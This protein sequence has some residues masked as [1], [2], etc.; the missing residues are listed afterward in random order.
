MSSGPPFLC[1]LALKINLH[2]QPSRNAGWLSGYQQTEGLQKKCWWALKGKTKKKKRKQ[3]WLVPKAIP[4]PPRQG[5]QQDCWLAL[6]GAGWQVFKG[7]CCLATKGSSTNKQG[8]LP[9]PADAL[10]EHTTVGHGVECGKN[11]ERLSAAPCR[12][13]SPGHRQCSSRTWCLAGSQG[14]VGAPVFWATH[15]WSASK[16]HQKKNG[17]CSGAPEKL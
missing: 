7:I 9:G 2:K 1:W 15:V 3:G 5:K 14:T 16:G 13:R 6:R 11:P 4:I 8:M 17:K 10:S 12:R